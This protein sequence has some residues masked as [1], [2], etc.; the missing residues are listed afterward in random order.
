MIRVGIAVF[1]VVLWA[2]APAGPPGGRLVHAQGPLR[3]S[4]ANPRYFTDGAGKAVYLAGAH[5]GWELQDCAWGDKNPGVQFDWDGFL[6]FLGR[7]GHNVIRLWCVEHTRI[8]DDDP[9]G[10]GQGKELHRWLG[11]S[12][13]IT[14]R[15]RAYVRKVIDTVNDLDNVL[16]EI[17]NESHG[18]SLDWQSRMTEYIRKYE[19][20]KPKQHPVGI[21]VPFRASWKPGLNGEL[22]RTPA[23]WISPNREAGGYGFRDNPPPADGRK[24]VLSDTDHFFGVGCKDYKWVWKTFTRGHNLLYMDMWTIERHAGREG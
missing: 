15:Q 11:E 16:Y 7:H 2:V 21:S 14:E 5:D 4:N 10:D 24:V 20:A 12:H 19:R 17:A 8:T 9:N 18:D 23:D 13:P 1:G 6:D 3:V 22:L